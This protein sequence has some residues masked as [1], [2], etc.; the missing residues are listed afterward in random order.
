VKEIEIEK[1]I[2]LEIDIERKRGKEI[3]KEIENIKVTEEVP[4]LN[5]EAS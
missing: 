5:K 2:D 1:K 4:L 3:V